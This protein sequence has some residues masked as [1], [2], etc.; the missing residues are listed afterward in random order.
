MT[1]RFPIRAATANGTRSAMEGRGECRRSRFSILVLLFT[2]HCSLVATAGCYSTRYHVRD[3]AAFAPAA[4]NERVLHRFSQTRRTWFALWGLLPL[5]ENEPLERVV[6]EE[7]GDGKR[8]AVRNLLITREVTPLDW[9]SLFGQTFSIGLASALVNPVIGVATIAVV[10]PWS[11]IVSGDV[12]ERESPR[13]SVAPTLESM[14]GGRDH[15]L[16]CEEEVSASP[17]SRSQ[18]ARPADPSQGRQFVD[19]SEFT[20]KGAY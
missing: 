18:V 7:V 5:N 2:V 11:T 3:D 15:S 6:E 10:M 4:E 20:R 19:L 1:S 17:P 12:V 8:L 9:F 13:A 16:R 14:G